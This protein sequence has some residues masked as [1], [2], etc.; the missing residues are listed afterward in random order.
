MPGIPTKFVIAE[1]VLK[2][3]I[4]ANEPKAAILG[5][6]DNLPFYYLG[7]IGAAFGDFIAARPEKGAATPNSTYFQVWFPVL[8]MF[9]GT[10]A[11][12]ATPA[13]GGVYKDLKQLRDTVNKLDG[14]VKKA[15]NGNAAE[16]DSQKIKLLN[17]KDELTAL[18]A[19]IADLQNTVATLATVRTT[20]GQSIFTSKPSPKTAPS[21]NWQVR[22]TLHESHTGQFLKAAY[23][24]ATDDKQKAYALGATVGY[25]ADLCG[26]PFVN[27]IVGAPIGIIG[28]GIAGSATM[29]TLGSTATT[30][31]AAPTPS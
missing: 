4:A 17:M 6:A 22:D 12:G 16:K 21:Q 23:D 26:N 10:P 30:L 15:V 3:L 31:R 18:N 29:S 13:T 2:A 27:N 25:A 9:A 11:Q 5:N 28:G 20:I 14:I 8:Q 1:K 24:L 7:A 19:V